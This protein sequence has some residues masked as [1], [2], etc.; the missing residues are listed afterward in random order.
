MFQGLVFCYLAEYSSFQYSSKC[1]REGPAL[2]H[3]SGASVLI[4]FRG[5]LLC[6]ALLGFGQEDV[7]GR[8][9]LQ[10]CGLCVWAST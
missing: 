7:S 9:A 2:M 5:A 4:W 6:T 3:Y 1:A 10:S 8:S